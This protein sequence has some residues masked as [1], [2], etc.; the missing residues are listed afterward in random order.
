[1]V[2][3]RFPTRPNYDNI[4]L[5]WKPRKKLALTSRGGFKDFS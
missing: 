1:M 4:G 3:I 2:F 5:M